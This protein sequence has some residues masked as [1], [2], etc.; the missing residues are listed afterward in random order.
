M[1]VVIKRLLSSNKNI[2]GR[3]EIIREDNF[4]LFNCRT[5]ELPYKSNIVSISSIPVGLYQ[6]KKHIS[7]KFGNCFKVLNVSGRSSILIHAG[8][9][10]T[11]TKGCILV[12]SVVSFDDHKFENVILNSRS[13]LKSLLATLPNSFTVEIS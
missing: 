1:R 13:T 10:S 12:G 3:L 4:C 11:D 7:P 9:F 5:L 8:N 2:I 6:V